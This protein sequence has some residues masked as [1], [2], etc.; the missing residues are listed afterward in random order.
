LGYTAAQAARLAGCTPSQLAHWVRR[1]VVH[2]SEGPGSY[3]FRDLV[4]LRVVASLLEAGLPLARAKAAILAVRTSGD[5]LA[6]LRV[7]TDGATV[8]ACREDGEILDALSGGQLALFV[9]VDRFAA[10]LEAD[11]RAFDAERLAFVEQL[12]ALGPADASGGTDTH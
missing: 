9:S 12:R 5:E 2:P 4:E 1:G 3:S 8:W 7:V 10:A 11:V 6:G